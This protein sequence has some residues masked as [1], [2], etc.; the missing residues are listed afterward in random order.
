V[1]DS[2]EPGVKY[3]LLIEAGKIKAEHDFTPVGRR[4]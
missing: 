4:L 1:P 2:L 3:R